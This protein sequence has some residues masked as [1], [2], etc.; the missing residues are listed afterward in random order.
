MQTILLLHGALG[1]AS[2][3]EPLAE[4]LA[5]KFDVH[6]LNFSGHGGSAMPDKPFDMQMFAEEVLRYIAA[7]DL[8]RPAIF[9]YSMGGYVGMYLA[10]NYPGKISSL[11]TLATK[12][13]WDA[14]IAAKEMKM[15]DPAQTALKVP[16]FAAA[17]QERH[18]PNDWKELMHKTADMIR[19]LGD[20]NALKPEDYPH[21]TI[22]CLLLR[23]DRDKMIKLEE[24]VG[25]YGLLPDARMGILPATGHPVEQLDLQLVSCMIS[26]FLL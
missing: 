12:F 4:A 19:R 14:A 20:D 21:I 13:Y 9:G 18:A 7:N 1:S 2:Q 16:A 10:R 6:R 5:H 15:L 22:P 24:T 11:I 26:S 25:T 17:L 23:G 8:D 3:L